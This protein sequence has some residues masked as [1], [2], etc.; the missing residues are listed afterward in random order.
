MIVEVAYNPATRAVEIYFNGNQIADCPILDL[1][2]GF[3]IQ[4]E[5]DGIPY[6]IDEG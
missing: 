1:D 3:H 6:T 4:I 5:D 2:K